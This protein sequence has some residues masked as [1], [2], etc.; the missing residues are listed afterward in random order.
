MLL[1]ALFKK[2]RLKMMKKRATSDADCPKMNVLN[3]VLRN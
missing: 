3:A 2:D 1:N